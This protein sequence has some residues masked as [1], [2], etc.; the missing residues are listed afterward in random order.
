MKHV[1]N[2]ILAA[3]LGVVLCSCATRDTSQVGS[4]SAYYYTP[5]DTGANAVWPRHVVSGATDYTIY[6]PQVDS[7]DGHQLMARSAVGVQGARQPQP[8]YGVVAIQALTLVDKSTRTVSLENIRVVGGDFPSA[9]QRIQSYLKS[10]RKSFPKQL[11]GLSLDHLEASLAVTPQQL[12]GSASPLN[13][14]PPNI[15]FSTR[16]A[17]LV[18]IDGPPVY[19]PVAGTELQRVINTRLLL[20]KDNAG[21]F[22]LHIRDG[23]MTSPGLAGSWRVANEPPK[24]AAE[25]EKQALASPTPVDL[26][27]GQADVP[28][29]KPP[30][31]T[32]ATAPIIYVA[33]QPTELILFDGPPNLIPI[34]R[35]H[36]VYV[37]NTSGNVFK[38]LTD[39]QT[40]VLISGRWFRAPSL[41]GPWQFVPA[42]HLAPDFANIPDTSPKENVKA[43]VP[44]TAQA[45]EAL[46]ANS[47]PQ[48]TKVPRN[49]QMQSPQ[50]DG[51]PSLQ[52]IA[53]TA[54]H[55][56]A[57]SGTPIVEVNPQSWYACQNGVW[58]AAPSVNGPWT[59]AASVPSVIYTIPPSSP[60]HY[61]TYVQIYDATPEFVYEGYTPGYWGTEVENGVVVYGT[62]YDYPPWIGDYWYGWPC[63]W[64][65]GWAPCWTPWD[66]WCFDDGFGWG[67]GF[68]RFAWSRCHPPRPWWGPHR[69]C[70]YNGGLMAWR[71]SDTASTAGNLYARQG[72][73]G[74]AGMRQWDRADTAGYYARS[75]NSRTGAMGAGQRAS[76]PNVQGSLLAHGGE[77]QFWDSRGSSLPFSTVGH[78]NNARAFRALG[79][80]GHEPAGGWRGYS[81][82]GSYAHGFAGG[83]GRSHGG[84]GGGWGRGGGGG[85]GHGGGGGGGHGGGGGGGGHR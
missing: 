72:T 61:L 35:T 69:D 46:I 25:A 55:Y 28:A 52:P 45:T 50:I 56:V 37:A 8:T 24:G 57:N 5:S 33:T 7:W 21:Q 42:D 81:Y 82:R 83:G 70:H 78:G 77:G 26:V 29:N 68:G 36:L 67:C 75:Y 71:R 32:G 1:L 27:D 31:L 85:G 14:A 16:P 10:L 65:F 62:G 64:G 51:P 41:D 54:L 79:F 84:W 4:G 9:E 15:I 80:S 39:Q 11:A 44:G 40:Y 23:Y 2:W 73:R 49:L 6:E 22:Y 3:G 74:G 43:S 53:G 30:P 19:R 20:L 63:T 76:V 58:Y 47:I 38:W 59:P 48:S 34:P 17:A 66:D 18:Y 60:L 13:N 12:N